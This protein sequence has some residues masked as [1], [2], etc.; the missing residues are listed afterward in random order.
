MA[1]SVVSGPLRVQTKETDGGLFVP[2]K[3]GSF[4]TGTWTDTRIAAGDYVMRKTALAQAGQ[5]VFHVGS[6]LLHKVG[7]DPMSGG[8]TH[9]IRG[10][11]LSSID[12]IYGIGTAALVTHTYDILQTTYANNVANAVV[13]TV[14]GTL[15]GALATATQA[16][17]YVTRITLGTLY[18]LGANTALRNVTLEI[19]WDAAATSVLDYYG[20]YLN[21]NYNLL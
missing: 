15:S 14:G 9:D 11:E 4:Y 12:L 1:E 6:Y 20:C 7:A 8:L 3:L 17:P 10:I 5:A 16:N 2:A 21:F 18:V 19:S 13:A